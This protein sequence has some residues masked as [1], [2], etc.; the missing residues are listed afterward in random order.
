MCNLPWL[1]T[2]LTLAALGCSGASAPVQPVNPLPQGTSPNAP[3]A[4]VQAL[5]FYHVALDPAALT[6]TVE[7]RP[8]R[9]AAATDDLYQLSIDRFLGPDSFQVRRIQT[10]GT[11][12]DITYRLSHPFPAPENPGGP[13]NGFSNRA[14]L[15]IAGMTLFLLDVPGATGNV[16]F[17][18]VIA[19]TGLITNAD[20]YFRPN[21]LLPSLPGVNVANTFPYLTF[22]DERGNGNRVDRPNGG[23]PT[24]NYGADG[25]TSAELGGAFGTGWT[26][27]GVLHQG[28]SAES[29]V[30]LKL[31]Q[32]GLGPV[33]FT[34]ALIAKYNDPRGG[35]TSGEKRS[36]RLP[37]FTP[38]PFS[39]AYR[40]PHG[41]LDTERIIF[42]G[43]S[44]GFIP[45]AASFSELRFH[46]TDWDARSPE[47]LFSSLADDPAVTNVAQG[48][49]GLPQLAI[50]IPGVLGTEFDVD[51]WDPVATI[52]DDDSGYGGD[53]AQ[54]SGRPGDALF[55]RKMV[56]KG[57]GTGQG[58]G[59]FT[60]LI[61]AQD[62]QPPG[63]VLAL[64][65][66]T[67]LPLTGTAPDPAI[68]QAFTV[69]MVEPSTPGWAIQWG[70]AGTE[71][72][73]GAHVTP[74]GEL[75]V[76]GFFAGSV[77]FGGG[78]RTASGANDA[79]LIKVDSTGAYQWD[80]TFGG[81]GSD[82]VYAIASDSTGHVIA[83]GY[84][85][86]DAN[87]GGG[88]RVN[89][90]MADA[91]FVKFDSAGTYVWDRTF[92]SSSGGFDQVLGVG[93]DPSDNVLISGSAVGN[94]DFGGGLRTAFN[95]AD[96]YV[97]KYSPANVHQWD[98][99]LAGTSIDM[100][101]NV[102]ADASGNVYV[103]GEIRSA[104]IGGGV[105]GSAGGGDGYVVKLTAS[106]LFLWNRWWGSTLNETT[107]ALA[108]NPVTG[109][110]YVGGAFQNSVDFGGGT[111]SSLSGFDAF[112]VKYDTTGTYQWDVVYGTSAAT[113][114]KVF[115]LAVAPAG[116]LF[117]G[118][119]YGGDFNFG[120]G[121]RTNAGGEDAFLVKLSAGGVYQWDA[122]FSD[123][124]TQRMV[125]VGS[126]LNGDVRG[127]G[128]F[129]GA[130]DFNPGPGSLILT[131]TGGGQDLFGLKLN[132][133][134][135][136]F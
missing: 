132:G 66:A 102:R 10:T 78:I 11:T 22:V 6:A 61:R 15:G 38:D 3:A 134:T 49:S 16:W 94:T 81:S 50:C 57:A 14:D 65:A 89:T 93:I 86:G 44:G 32:L 21:D 91:Y 106:G 109:D 29:K 13:P 70:A 74:A 60:G 4:A 135:G 124:G 36:N 123:L 121:L 31:S 2:A 97:A 27:Y 43:E 73:E 52:E 59:V 114:D 119:V 110:V 45:N 46:V 87:F 120:G 92:G 90:G 56:G 115:S 127:A 100:A 1:A 53:G 72:I 122:T 131:A 108:V 54:D 35:V 77:D 5:A 30:S 68:Y 28:Q 48:E 107:D 82:R 104:D 129:A 113:Q 34:V 136:V 88:L 96:G 67:L 62:P 130:V 58:G 39:F 71:S 7:Q 25:W 75:L 55:F 26:G 98:K 20:G 41:A 80:R 99:W 8:Y 105:I 47:T 79:F 40:M 69:T 101:Q 118:G 42:Q 76:G 63:M 103:A 85:T 116:A 126:D 112:I 19:N 133:T 117:V 83:G 125:D 18:D 95:L 111:R 9:Q 24:G 23:D 17:S 128:N 12:L 37:P 33:N 51:F 64:D 84:F